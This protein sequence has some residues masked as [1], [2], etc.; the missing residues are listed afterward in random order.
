VSDDPNLSELTDD[1]K[2]PPE[3][4]PDEPLGVE[5]YGVTAAE[6]E[7]PEP[8]A[9]RVARE[10]PDLLPPDDDSEYGRPVGTLVE[11]DEGIVDRDFEADAVATEAGMPPGE[12][13]IDADDIAFGDDTLR[14]VAQEREGTELSAEEAA[15]HLTPPPPMGDGDGY[16]EDE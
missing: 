12:L 16:L 8:L 5:D 13:S 14:D 7:I 6:E 4:P 11:P 10:E 1:D 3:Y 2:L 15:M 9:E